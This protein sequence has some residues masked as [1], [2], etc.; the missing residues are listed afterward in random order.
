MHLDL[1]LTCICTPPVGE[2]RR[3]QGGVKQKMASSV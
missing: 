1:Y 2:H 3:G